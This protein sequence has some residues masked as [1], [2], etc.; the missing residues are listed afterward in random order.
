[1]PSSSDKKVELWLPTSQTKVTVIDGE[2]K[3]WD[4]MNMEKRIIQK[5]AGFVKEE[6]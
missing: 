1:M 4:E 5:P 2:V 6:K 3:V